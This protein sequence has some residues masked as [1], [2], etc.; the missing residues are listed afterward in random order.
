MLPFVSAASVFGA[1]S[2][3]AALETPRR[4][5]RGP[6]ARSGSAPPQENPLHKITDLFGIDSSTRRASWPPAAEPILISNAIPPYASAPGV[7][8]P[9]LR[10][11]VLKGFGDPVPVAHAPHGSTLHFVT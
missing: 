6:A 4:N 11:I 5:F 9:Q 10:E 7:C 1:A 3:R 8:S 2:D